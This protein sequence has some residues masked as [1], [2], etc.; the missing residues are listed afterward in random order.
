VAGRETLVAADEKPQLT[1]LMRGYLTEMTARLGLAEMDAYPDLDLYWSEPATRWPY[2]ISDDDR[3][4]GF[5][6]VRFNQA[7]AC[8]EMAE[9]FVARSYRRKGIGIAAAR[10]IIARH[11]G[12]WRITQWEVNAAAIAFWH[13]VLDGYAYEETRTAS[14]VLR[15]E[16]RFTIPPVAAGLAHPFVR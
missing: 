8:L 6:L 10:R 5:A 16:Q 1:A 3:H 11:P 14:D 2:W 9:F 13:R 12:N 15:R 4:V 7:L